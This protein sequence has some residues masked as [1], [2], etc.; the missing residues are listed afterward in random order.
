ML[1]EKQLSE[2][3]EHLEKAQNPVFFYDNDVDGLCSYIL[4]R[5]FI[6]SGKGVAVKSHPDVDRNYARKAQELN[7]DYVFVL[8]RPHLGNEFV[9]EIKSLQLPIVWLDH[10]DMGD[11]KY[12]YGDLFVYNPQ[13]NKKKSGEPTT[14]LAYSITKRREDMWI[15]LMGCIADHYL[16]SFSEDFEN[17]FPEFWAKGIKEPFDAYYSSGI[18]RL[19]RALSFGIKDSISHVVQLQNFLINCRN[20]S[21]MEIELEN[22][23][24]FGKKFREINKKYSQLI[25]KAKEEVDDKM[26]FFSYGGSMS[27]SADI[28]NELS[29]IYPDKV[30]AVAYSSGPI[31]NVS[32]RGKDVRKMLGEI[33]PLL[34]EGTGGGHEMAV[35]SR[36][37][38]EDLEKFKEE[39][40]KRL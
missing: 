39:L 5:R 17:E 3:R 21:E 16:P 32:L 31:T 15:A 4:L 10:H 12:D 27:I 29:H 35:G 9:E 26:L 11:E 8:D 20:P 25:E 22:N 2:L 30:I 36:I 18:G 34:S 38:T 6:G 33:L 14:Y 1:S 37:R 23:R 7:A 19:A 13:K 40:S 24:A 28:S